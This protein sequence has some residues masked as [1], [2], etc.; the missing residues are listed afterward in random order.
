ME[1]YQIKKKPVHLPN[2]LVNVAACFSSSLGRR[3]FRMS[4]QMLAAE[5]FKA[6]DAELQKNE[7]PF[8]KLAG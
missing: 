6:D 5:E 4:C 1:E 8:Y 7:H 2:S 3:F